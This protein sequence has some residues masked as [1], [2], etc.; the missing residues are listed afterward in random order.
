MKEK[1]KEP[2]QV[3]K[4]MGC[5]DMTH[6]SHDSTCFLNHLPSGANIATRPTTSFSSSSS[7]KNLDF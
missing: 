2:S 6:F 4:E 7:E 3:G 5:K 1:H